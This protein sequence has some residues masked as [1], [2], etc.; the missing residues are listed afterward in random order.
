MAELFGFELRK[1]RPTSDLPS[2]APPKDADDGAVVVSAGGAYGT[3]VDLDGTVRSEAELVTKY[4][5]MSLQPEV[6]SAIDEIVN[7]AIAID[8][9]HVVT[10]NLDELQVKENIK[11]VIRQEFQNCLRCK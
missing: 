10:I 8:E 2:F 9:Q 11:Q 7:E 6:D 5:E 1:R 4:R 3:Y